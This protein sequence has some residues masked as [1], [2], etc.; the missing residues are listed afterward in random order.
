LSEALVNNADPSS[1]I[2]FQVGTV[3]KVASIATIQNGMSDIGIYLN[4]PGDA[5]QLQ[6]FTRDGRQILGAALSA[7][8]QSQIFSAANGFELGSTY[9]TTY[10]NQKGDLSY[11]D[12]SVFYGAKA[13]VQLIPQW[14]MQEKNPEKHTV[15]NPIKAP[16]QLNGKAI[17]SMSQIQDGM[18]K[19]N[20]V[21]LSEWSSS[22]DKD[23][24][25]VDVKAWLDTNIESYPSTL[26]GFKVTAQN[27][28]KI[29]RSQ[30]NLSDP[31]KSKYLSINGTPLSEVDTEW[32][33]PEELVQEINNQSES[34]GVQA[35]V[36]DNGDIVITNTEGNE[37]QDITIDSG[38]IPNAFGIEAGTYK[39]SINITRDLDPNVDTPIELG[40]GTGKP[41]DLSKLGFT[42]GAFIKG[43]TQEDLL[44][45][46]TGSG[47]A[48]VSATYSGSRADSKE[49]LRAQPLEIKFATRK[50][51]N[52]DQS[53][54]TITDLSTKTE[55]AR[56]DFDPTQPELFLN[57][58]GLKISFSNPPAAGDTYTVD[59]N[60]DGVGNNEN[61]IAIANLENKGVMGGG[62]TLGAYYIDQVNDMGNIARQAAISQSA[63]KVVYDQ[64]VTA[65]D[66]VSGVSL[67][68]EAADLIRFQQ[69]Y[70]AA[71]KILQVASQL[72]D[73]V[74]SV[75]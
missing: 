47:T 3:R 52:V 28:I 9:S 66:E 63:L 4:T 26:G 45:F 15:L 11:K 48:N 54:Y 20:G 32:S 37:G 2:N 19:L 6:V 1:G 44:V 13:D 17:G 64:A 42:T 35:M 46:V 40:F 65:R 60:R 71:A 16:A 50:E 5:Q 53:Y 38:A 23:L 29:P 27:E 58:Q 33:S 69:A 49:T 31:S 7:E 61:M 56:R 68:Q 22:N 30:L 55:V 59:G 57:Y 41:S 75:R 21:S 14:D 8:D 72:F 43:Q 24:Q 34:T 12:M 74:L 39:G 36:S 51:N 18:F 10:L 67:D 73:S 62:K 70:Q 25:A